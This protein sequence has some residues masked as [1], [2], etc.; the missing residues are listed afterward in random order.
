M[1]PTTQIPERYTGKMVGTV[2]LLLAVFSTPSFAQSMLGERNVFVMGVGNVSCGKWLE[3]KSDSFVRAQRMQWLL[4]YLSAYNGFNTKNQVQPNDVES[5]MAFMD[6]YC[7]NNPLHITFFGANALIDEL[8]GMKAK[9][10]W[11]R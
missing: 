8:G 9:H 10:S 7:S 3:D 4:G 2:L 5:A 1:T 11:K 6:L